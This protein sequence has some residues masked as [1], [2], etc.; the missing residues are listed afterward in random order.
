MSVGMHFVY[1]V[2]F[3]ENLVLSFLALLERRSGAG[4][5]G[6]GRGELRIQYKSYFTEEVVHPLPLSRVHNKIPQQGCANHTQNNVG[7]VG[8][9]TAPPCGIKKKL[10]LTFMLTSVGMCR[11]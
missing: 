6:E 8:P 10:F 5:P 2:P 4:G 9:C 7:S 3:C 11:M 1:D